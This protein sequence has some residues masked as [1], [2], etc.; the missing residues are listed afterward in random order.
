M[1]PHLVR[2]FGKEKEEVV[3]FLEERYY[4]T[5]HDRTGALDLFGIIRFQTFSDEHIHTL[6]YR[7]N[8]REI[9]PKQ[10]AHMADTAAC[11]DR[12]AERTL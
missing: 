3:I 5:R 12:S 7:D 2:P 4:H 8:G 6:L 9:N 11:R 10:F 1:K